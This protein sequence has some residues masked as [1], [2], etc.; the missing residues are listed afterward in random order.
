MTDYEKK[1]VSVGTLKKGDT[2]ILEGS[3]CK[4]TDTATSRPGKH[5]H[6]KV[7]LTAVGILDGKKRQTVMPGH[8]KVEAP[9]IEKKN[10]QVLSV[11]GNMASVMDAETY[12][13]FDMEIPEELRKDVKEGVE[14][15]YWVIM[16]A[17]VMKQIK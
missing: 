1:L 2:I 3:P 12:E 11:S 14:V 7:N 17:N 13:T 9:I 6:A 4:I 15:L 8:D 5:G 10:A 16:G